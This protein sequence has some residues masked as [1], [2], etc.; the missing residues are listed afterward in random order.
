VKFG[1]D[2]GGGNGRGCFEV[3]VKTDETKLT[4]VIITG[5]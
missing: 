5:L 3:E 2:N 1:V 4:N